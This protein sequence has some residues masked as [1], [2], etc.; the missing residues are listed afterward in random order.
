ML[1]YISPLTGLGMGKKMSLI[2][3]WALACALLLGASMAH[4]AGLGKLTVNSSLGQILNAEID[5]VSLQPGEL[6]ALSARVAPAEAFRDARIEFSNSLRLLRFAID[7]RA[8][9]QPYI[10]ISSVAP[11]N[12]PFVDMLIEV[13]WPAGRIQREYPILL[14]PPG[15]SSRS[16]PPTVAAA[17]ATSRPADSPPASAPA[18]SSPPAASTGTAPS[19]GTPSA[20]AELASTPAAAPRDAP[21]PGADTYGPVERGDTLNKIASQVKP[22]NV[23]LE[24]MLVALYRENQSAFVNN[25]MNRLKTGQILKVPSA[26]DIEKI[27]VKEANQEYRTH[28]ADWNAY[29]GQL[30]GGVASIPARAEPSNVAAGRVASAAVTPPAPPAAETKDVLKLSKSDVGA[31][32]AG[33]AKGAS[34]QE[35]LNALQEELTA[36]DKAL[37]ESQ[38]RVTDLEKQI[39][40]MQRLLDLKAGAPAKTDSKVA[41]APPPAKVEPPK[42]V[43]PPKVA[44]APPTPAKVEPSKPVEPAKVEPAKPPEPPKVAEA[45]KPAPPKVAE[46][47]PAPPKAAAPKKGPA[48]PPE[49]GMVDELM[50][51]PAWLMGGLGVLAAIGIG[52]FLFV[53]RRKA[54]AEAGP[55]SSMTSAFP[56]DL[57]P[58][59]T[60]GKAGG[61][62]V[63]TGNSSFLTDF[64]KTGPG[65]IDTDEVDPVAEAEVY[66][67]YG[68]DAQAEEILKEAM[69]R[70]KGR[71]EIALKLLEIYHA[72]KSATAFETVAKE[73]RSAVGESSPLWT[74]AAAMG[75]QIDPTNPLYAAGASSAG[76]YT[77][78]AAAAAKPD[79]DFGID[80]S[81][82]PSQPAPDF[83]LDVDPTRSRSPESTGSQP[84][85]TSGMDFDI[86]APS[87]SAPA[88][89][90][91]KQETPPSFDFDL[92]GLDFPG[93]K[94][95][96]T[97]GDMETTN[98]PAPMADL[99]LDMPSGGGGG[100]GSEAV[101]TKL[102]LAKAYLEIGDKDGAR[103][104]LQEVAKEGSPSQK[105]EAE[106]LISSL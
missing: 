47:K 39:R 2:T 44:A 9:G 98:T 84:A 75:A 93:S 20:T 18:A 99:S 69:A 85:A 56:S 22:S 28:V 19:T 70:D 5:L 102:E 25:N 105:E 14:D 94:P 65:T 79:V 67:A 29:R 83:D 77:P 59:S 52:A 72:R 82:T 103:E 49:K 64:D 6:D 92:S 54:G 86:H 68:R 48:P 106:K 12:E 88:A 60:A 11:I 76:S 43:E 8:N 42:A 78:S 95:A 3:R 50:D 46:A 91:P 40:D 81:A 74:K 66:I 16:S 51:N 30:A 7:K 13:S 58:S 17:P 80:E 63:D 4:A 21:A 55:S 33:A 100:G 38:S 41:V 62:L 53:R 35:R 37:R 57:K 96:A 1:F 90:A 89:E 10:K 31:G 71:H 104:I 97:A 23:S 27:A 45:P 87:E 73:L 24:Q 32:K 34:G 101:G 61:G 15:Y 36:K 26:P